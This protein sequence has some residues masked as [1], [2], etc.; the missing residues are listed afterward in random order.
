MLFRNGPG[1]IVGRHRRAWRWTLPVPFLFFF[2]GGGRLP[3]GRVFAHVVF[4]GFQLGGVVYDPVHDGV[5]VCMCSIG[6]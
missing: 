6:C 3:D 1:V 4:A 2:L 5:G